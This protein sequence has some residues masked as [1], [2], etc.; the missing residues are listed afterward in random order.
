V[1]KWR[2]YILSGGRSS[3]FGSDKARAAV[4]GRPLIS[5][6]A[7]SLQPVSHSVV[8]VADEADKYDD[9]SLTTIADPVSHLGP[10]GGLQT[11]L[12]HLLSNR[13]E[14]WLL[15]AACDHTE[16]RTGWIAQLAATPTDSCQCVAFYDSAWQPFPGL[17]HTSLLPPIEKLFTAGRRSIQALLD[18]TDALSVP[19][20]DD[21]PSIAQ[22]NTV[23]QWRQV[24]GGRMPES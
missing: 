23:D 24:V 9:L 4:E 3:R 22:I 5:R 14:G 13:G 11:A 20:P 17:Y 1:T 6:V 7:E 12:A 2:A 8:V 18:S 10:L 16:I 21:W 19:L 15:L